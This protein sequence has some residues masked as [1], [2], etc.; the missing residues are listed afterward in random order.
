MNIK[1][2]GL[3]LILNLFVASVTFSQTVQKFQINFETTIYKLSVD[4]EK[5]IDSVLN[6]LS[7]IPQAY[8]FE[9]T[10][11]TDNVGSL[12]FNMA[13]SKN[14]ANEIAKY[15][16]TKGFIK[17][18]MITLGKGYSEP[19]ADNETEKGKSTNRRVSVTISLDLPKIKSI[20][21]IQIKDNGYKIKVES[22]QVIVHPSGTKIL[23]PPNAFVDKHDKQVLGEIDLIYREYREPI[24]FIFGGIPMNYVTNGNL[25]HFNSAGMFKIL[26]YKNGVPVFLKSGENIQIDFAV[27]ENLADMNFYRFDTISNQWTEIAQL[28]D[29]NGNNFS[30]NAYAGLRPCGYV[31][32]TTVCTME[33][34]DALYYIVK[35]GIRFASRQESIYAALQPKDLL[36]SIKT[37]DQI[38]KNNLKEKEF[39][40]DSVAKKIKEEKHIYNLKK[41]T[42]NKSKIVFN[43]QCEAKNN[44]GIAAFKNADW[45]YNTTKNPALSNT[46]FKKQ[47]E[48]CQIVFSGKD[49][50]IILKDSVDEVSINNLQIIIKEKIRKKDKE[51][52]L[53]SRHSEYETLIAQQNIS[54]EDLNASKKILIS[55]KKNILSKVDSLGKIKQSNDSISNLLNS[56]SL[57]CFW[58]KSKSTMPT[59]ETT[60]KFEEW[61][62]EFDANKPEMLKRYIELKQNPQYEYCEKV[63]IQKEE[64]RK[65]F[66]EVKKQQE[67]ADKNASN[68]LKSMSISN[69]GIYNCDQIKTLSNPVEVL[70]DYKD[71]NG[72][73]IE[74]LFIYLLDNTLNGVIRYDGY[75]G[76]SPY[77]FAFSPTSTNTLIA[78]DD[79]GTAYIFSSDKFKSIDIKRKQLYHTFILDEIE[80]LKSRNDL[81]EQL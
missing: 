11:H 44:N 30:A 25:Y 73:K 47:W 53:Q 2:Y 27:T 43:I 50:N 52:Y 1:K 45:E 31:N 37:T 76:Y 4:Q 16:E 55:E 80:N 38:L 20:G 18:K 70:A 35:A 8:K 26:A 81:K 63:A 17:K 57:F 65:R 42:N 28:T 46:I 34:C 14:R 71:K 19:I 7:N 54:I 64:M 62:K 32:G 48:S 60:M 78:I 59:N 66:E 6:L 21:G 75:M 40:I 13:L 23:I 58:D 5:R 67:S 51:S 39:K 72:K 41:V 61:L 77:R 69:L 49:F 15:F 12:P 68:I 56:D 22:G 3:L 74:P 10:G 9:I 36:N 79:K 29:L 33:E 24:D